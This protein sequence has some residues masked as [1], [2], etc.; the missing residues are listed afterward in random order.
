MSLDG[1]EWET[2][3]EDKLKARNAREKMM[4]EDDIREILSTPIRPKRPSL[5]TIMSG[6]PVRGKRLNFGFDDEDEE[7]S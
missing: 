5:D 1:R 2:C 6:S 7:L 3:K 4:G